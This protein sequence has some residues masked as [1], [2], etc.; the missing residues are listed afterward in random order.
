[1]KRW[2]A[3]LAAALAALVAV[4]CANLDEKQRA[5]IFQPSDATWGR[6]AELARGMDS[7]W[8]DFDSAVTHE[9]A[10]L[11]ALWAAEG[12]RRDGPVLLY[13][14]GARW[15]VESSAPRVRRLQEMGF[16]VLAIDYRGFGKSS[17]GLPSEQ[18]AYE[19]AQAAWRW[20]AAKYPNRPRYIFGHSLG[21]AIAIDLAASV[22]DE[23]GTIVEATF[24]SI[25][26]V[27]ASTKWGWLPVGPLIT[28][29]FDSM[30]K[31]RKLGSPLLVVHGDSD[32]LIDTS[33]GR[34]LYEAAA[35]PKKLLVVEGGTHHSTMSVGFAQYKQALSDVFGLH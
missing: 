11:H 23:R 12:A 13:L 35:Q 20:L 21:G 5:W 32:S 1:M 3:F 25:P 26:D 22:P 24:T 14:H 8:I 33:L 28:Q 27:A 4:G 18:T 6:G 16:S 9:P 29:R 30:A 7:V 31:V 2:I 17:P 34:K 19:D 10:R 15:N